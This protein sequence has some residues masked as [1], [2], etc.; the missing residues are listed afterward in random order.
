MGF[1]SWLF[2]PWV[3][4]AKPG[5][6]HVDLDAIDSKSDNTNL[7]YVLD[8]KNKLRD[9]SSSHIGSHGVPVT[10]FKEEDQSFTPEGVARSM[11]LAEI[12][13]FLSSRNEEKTFSFDE[14]FKNA[15]EQRRS[16]SARQS[17]QSRHLAASNVDSGLRAQQDD[18]NSYE[19][20]TSI[21]EDIA[22]AAVEV[23]A[24]SS[25]FDSDS[26]DSSSNSDW[27]GGGGDFSGGGASDSFQ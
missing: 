23:A 10:P 12:K 1:I 7:E 15:S 22:T 2:H 21:V 26:S 11:S 18:S 13:E 25:L 24:L 9:I 6:H 16:L 27:S 8:L 14:A 4:K 3:H 19:A 17:D 20:T 5:E